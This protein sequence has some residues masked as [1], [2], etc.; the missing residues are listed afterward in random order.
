MNGSWPPATNTIKK[1]LVKRGVVSLATDLGC[2]MAFP[3]SYVVSDA[4]SFGL[5]GTPEEGLDAQAQPSGSKTRD[6]QPPTRRLTAV[7]SDLLSR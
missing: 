2:R 4:E 6:G 1:F 5:C 3:V 7:N